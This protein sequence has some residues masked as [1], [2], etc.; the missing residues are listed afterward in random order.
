MVKGM[1]A[2]FFKGLAFAAAVAAM[3]SCD[4]K[5]PEEKPAEPTFP[6]KQQI[7][8]AAGAQQEIKFTAEA[9]WKLTIDKTTWCAFL[10]NEVETAQLSGKAGEVV[11]TVLVKDTGLDFV[12]NVAKIDLTLGT[13][14]ETIY[15]ITRPGKAREVKLYVTQDEYGNEYKESEKIELA[16]GEW[17]VEKRKFTIVANYDWTVAAPEG[18]TFT[19]KSYQE[20]PGLSGTAGV[21]PDASDFTYATVSVK[22]ELVPYEKDAKIVVTDTD[23]NNPVEFVLHYLGMD[24]NTVNFDPQNIAGTNSRN[25]GLPF[26]ADGYK[27]EKS[28][29]ED[30]GTITTDKTASFSVQAKNMKYAVHKIEIVDNVAVEKADWVTVTD[31]KAGKIAVSVTENKGEERLA[32]IIVLSEE[33]DKNFKIADYYTYDEEYGGYLINDAYSSLS[34]KVS[35]KGISVAKD[36]SVLWGISYATVKTVEFSSYPEFAGRKASDY[37]GGSCDANAYVIE[38]T[39]ADVLTTYDGVTYYSAGALMIAPIGFPDDYY[40]VGST[41]SD[42]LFR[43]TPQTGDWK[44]ENLG[45]ASLYTSKGQVQGIQIDPAQFIDTEAKT[46]KNFKGTAVVQFYKT[47]ADKAAYKSS[48]TLVIVKK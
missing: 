3:V 10:D 46:S 33:A 7:E 5:A 40:P 4:K 18:F 25:V 39:D 23:G 28:Y 38:I 32:Y 9:D 8:I 17:G 21:G 6:Q 24:A 12:S 27:I 30:P 41:E 34:V 45:S 15:E 35:Q 2:L 47:A 43:F 19:D 36:F 26:T 11:A 1:K 48:A 13:K 16:Y 31:D 29:P 37:A 22:T 44:T 14:T 20:V 42:N